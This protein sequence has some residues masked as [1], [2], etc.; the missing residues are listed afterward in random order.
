LEVGETAVFRFRNGEFSEFS[1]EDGL[2]RDKILSIVPDSTGVLWMSS[3]N[4][5][6]GIKRQAFESYIRGTSPPLLCQRLSLSQG[7]ANRAARASVNRSAT[8]ILMGG[9]GFPTWKASRFSIR[10]WLRA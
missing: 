6:F 7:L 2:S 4:G 1:A 5:I 3:D 9:F 8:S 10:T